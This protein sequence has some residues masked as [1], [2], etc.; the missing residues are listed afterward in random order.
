MDSIDA[1]LCRHLLMNS[2]ASYA[3]LAHEVGISAQ[4]V[5]KR[6]EAMRTSGTIRKFNSRL[7][8]RAI[9]GFWAIAFGQAKIDEKRL[10]GRLGETRI[11]HAVMVSSGN[12][13]HVVL[14]LRDIGDLETFTS[15]A[16]K[17]N[18]VADLGVGMVAPGYVVSIPKGVATLS[19]LDLR[20]AD[21]LKDDSRRP[22]AEVA[23]A[24]GSTA[25]TVSRRLKRMED[26]A[27]LQMSM[28]WV[29]DQPGTVMTMAHIRLKAGVDLR[30]GYVSVLNAASQSLVFAYPMANVPDLL[31]CI[32]WA[33]S[34]AEMKASCE[35]L[36]KDERIRS[37]TP[38]VL[39]DGHYFRTWK[40][41]LLEEMLRRTKGSGSGRPPGPSPQSMSERQLLDCTSA[42][43]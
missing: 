3:S 21:A 13:V 19:G 24:V 11:A 17:E 27:S 30:S 38:Y 5:Q 25:K 37:V 20:I 39:H 9:G 33:G 18:L 42:H 32:L 15:L 6:I 2:R 1:A 36:A 29:P 35:S 22:V 14:E 7:G 41:D 34:M 12:Y 16:A 10:L 40:D 23:E 28:E 26:E 31:L 4:A 8:A 43:S